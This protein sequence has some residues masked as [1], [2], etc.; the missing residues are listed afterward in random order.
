MSI[1]IIQIMPDLKLILWKD[2]HLIALSFSSG[3]NNV[4][5]QPLQIPKGLPGQSDHEESVY[6][7]LLH[8][9]ALL[10]FSGVLSLPYRVAISIFS[11]A[12]WYTSFCNFFFKF[13]HEIP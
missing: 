6:V 1:S 10:G 12:I 4:A 5:S 9:I 3:F 2:H 8:F 13:G 11:L 7:A